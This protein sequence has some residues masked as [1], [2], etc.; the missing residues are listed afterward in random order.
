MS[1]L[2]SLTGGPDEMPGGGPAKVGVA[3]SDVITGIYSSFAVTAALYAREQSGRG[4]H[5]DMSLLDVQIAAISH[6][7]MN[8]LV[9]GR[10]P[11]R[12]GS[13]HPSIVPYQAFDC[14][15]GKIVVAVGNNRLFAKLCRALD[16]PHLLDDPRYAD[17]T[18]RVENREPLVRELS[19]RFQE[20]PAIHWLDELGTAGVP[21]GPI[22]DL[23][24]VFRDPHVI[25]REL[26][27]VMPHPVCG[28]LPFLAN[29]IRFSETEPQYRRP[30]PALGE[31]TAEVLE[32]ML[33]LDSAAQDALRKERV[34]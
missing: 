28:E 26:A 21:S 3:I 34:I 6:I 18:L 1:G 5:I 29:P 12:M 20:Q 31:H 30:P 9:G 19:E 10:I 32:S 24:D 23:R 15:D 7:N 25:A 2:M 8:Y 13:A 33:G 14:A 22:N 17:N 4:Q 27:R 11:K 16:L